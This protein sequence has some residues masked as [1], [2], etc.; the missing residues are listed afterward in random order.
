IGC[1]SFAGTLVE[2]ELQ[3]LRFTRGKIEL[4]NGAGLG[5]FPV[6][7]HGIFFLMND[8][9]VERVFEIRTLGRM[10]VEQ[11]NVGFIVREENF[12]RAVEFEY[13]SSQGGFIYLDFTVVG[14]I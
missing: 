12:W 2:P 13:V 14:E 1:R 11:R 8:V 5:P 3:C 4:I 9:V 6:R 7:P 10:V